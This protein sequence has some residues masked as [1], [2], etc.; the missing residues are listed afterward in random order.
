MRRKSSSARLL[1]ASACRSRVLQAYTLPV[2]PTPDD[3][4]Y[5]ATLDYLYAR[6]PMF[7]RIG[8]AALKP[9]LDN[10]LRL[11][12]ALGNPQ[13]KFQSVH[14]A[15][16]NGKGSTSHMLAVVF[17]KCGYKT[18]L[19]TSPH[20]VDF[21]E[22][23]RIGGTPV[24]KAWVV[25][26]VDRV[27]PEIERIQPSFFEITVVM[28][29]QYFAEQGVEVA[30][31][32]T[33]LGGR[34][35]STNVITPELSIITNISYDHA[36][37]LGPTLAHI[38]REKAGIIKP[39]VPVVIGEWGSEER[40]VVFEETAEARGSE[41]IWAEDQYAILPR[42]VH[43][44][45]ACYSAYHRPS[46]ETTEFRTDLL[47]RYQ[48]SNM[49][50]TLAALDAL[51]GVEWNLPPAAVQDALGNVRGTT[52]L[53]GRWEVL[54]DSPF[55]VADVA[56]NTAGLEAVLAQWGDIPARRKHIVAGFVRDKDVSS[57]L[58]LFP[59]DAQYYFCNAAIPRALPA[60]ELA[61]LAE[62]AGLPGKA[63]DSVEAA[64]GAAFGA[65]APED[66]LLITGSFF[67]VG[68]ALEVQSIAA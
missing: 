58:L 15:G 60:E 35:D 1:F 57:A 38:A 25:D 68:E 23:I 67:V 65:L 8:A 12:E 42:G 24:E 2:P 6:L 4:R 40:A 28:A 21:R 31:V 9:S 32:E 13:Q 49:A 53:R 3:A 33:G 51:R 29:F 59:K 62:Q 41:I 44:G 14:I 5:R 26:F 63:Y 46:K 18:G 61:A 43:D 17:Q 11:C 19:Y 56:H 10:T 55:V 54:Q 20:L 16:T 48:A 27:M 66:A 64:V 37:L 52:G 45:S 50:T 7:S 22:R 39:G 34:L 30:V 47:G 36:D